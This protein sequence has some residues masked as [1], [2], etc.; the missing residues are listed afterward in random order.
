MFLVL[1]ECKKEGV[2]AA[3]IGETCKSVYRRAAMHYQ[4]LK[5]LDPSNFMVRHNVQK[6]PEQDPACGE[7]YTWEVESFAVSALQREIQEA[8]LIKERYASESDT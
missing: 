8:L 1:L 2:D 7:N 3:F 4:K 6:H 5:S